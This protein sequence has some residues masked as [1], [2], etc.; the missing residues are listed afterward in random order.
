MPLCAYCTDLPLEHLLLA[1]GL[2]CSSTAVAVQLLP[3]VI[4]AVHAHQKSHFFYQKRPCGAPVAG[5]TRTDLSSLH[6][7][8]GLEGGSVPRGR[9]ARKLVLVLISA[10]FGLCIAQI[11]LYTETGSVQTGGG[12]A[13]GCW[14]LAG[15][16]RSSC[17]GRFRIRVQSRRDSVRAE[18][19]CFN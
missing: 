16:H 5:H 15:L 13:G 8:S 14:E 10:F 4:A 12:P 3:K 7:R 2:P 18:S 9:G 19:C 1:L 11:K 17:P 6:P